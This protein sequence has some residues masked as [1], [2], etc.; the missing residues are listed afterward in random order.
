MRP[1]AAPRQTRRDKYKPRPPVQRYHAFRDEVRIRHVQI[2]APYYH[3][4]FV[5][6]MP[7]S[8]SASQRTAARGRRHQQKPDKDNLEKALLDSV[9][10][11]DSHVW[12]GRVTKIWGDQD[13]IVISSAEIPIAEPV[14]L[15]PWE[16]A[17]RQP[18]T[19]ARNVAQ[20]AGDGLGSASAEEN[21]IPSATVRQGTRQAGAGRAAQDQH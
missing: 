21:P 5:L 4:V 9:F 16:E 15:R 8:W 10:G 20:H 12:D 18:Y 19:H 13:L 7:S 3:V 14:D 1:V 17:A 11:D 2:P 6:A